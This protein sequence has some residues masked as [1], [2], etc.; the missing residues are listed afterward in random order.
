MVKCLVTRKYWI[1]YGLVLFFNIQSQP[2]YGY[3]RLERFLE[4]AMFKK[5]G[6]S[7]DPKEVWEEFFRVVMKNEWKTALELIG[8]LKGLEPDNAQVH[9]KMGDILQRTGDSG[10]AVSA[11]HEAANCLSHAGD[12]SKA[13]AI[14]KIILRLAPEDSDAAERSRAI[15]DGSDQ[16]PP[17]QQDHMTYEQVEADAAAGYDEGESQEEGAPAYD[18][19]ES[20]EEGAPAYDEG[21]AVP[22]ELPALEDQLG[23]QPDE[24]A[25]SE[26]YEDGDSQEVG[27]GGTVSPFATAAEAPGPEPAGEPEPAP[28]AEPAPP[29]APPAA[30]QKAMGLHEAF[31]R[32]PMFSVLSDEDIDTM[33]K[34]ARH[35]VLKS[36]QP[37]IKEDEPG[38]SMFIIKKG[39]AKVTSTMFD[40]TYELA[41]L[42]GGNF[43]GEVGFLTGMPRTASVTASGDLSIMEI[44]KPLM[45]ELIE[46]NP[47][48]LQKLVELSHSRTQKKMKKMGDE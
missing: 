40:K 22:D 7:D 2:Y 1:G 29:Q 25:I 23:G 19:G 28:A 9:M 26:L 35:A 12:N 39:K 42:G 30:P 41:T 10:G 36:G 46:R 8:H 47:K 3:F 18:E 37:V 43:F 11:Y 38:D 13:L 17:Q 4:M 45:Q 44:N 34:K 27:Q 16:A 14:Y 20:Q 15:M 32:H 48:V 33:I 31:K 24:P 5:K 21:D 6:L